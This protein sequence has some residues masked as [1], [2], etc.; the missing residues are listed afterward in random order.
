MRYTNKEVKTM[1]NKKEVKKVVLN[2]KAISSILV[3]YDKEVNKEEKAK[4]G[5]KALVQ[6]L[7]D[8]VP[9]DWYLM[10]NEPIANKSNLID[11]LKN[12]YV[13]GYI[14][15][16]PELMHFK[17]GDIEYNFEVSDIFESDTKKLLEKYPNAEGYAFLVKAGGAR[18]KFSSAF[19][20]Y[21]NSLKKIAKSLFDTDNDDNDTENVDTQ[22]LAYIDSRI[23][24]D[25]NNRKSTLQHRSTSSKWYS[26][27]QAQLRIA[28]IDRAIKSI[29]SLDS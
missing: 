1:S 24:S 26:E 16:H 4:L 11:I 18:R 9:F 23:K 17:M 14:A 21:T 2:E 6:K 22:S 10:N 20:H 25:M 12:H 13:V 28:I 27:Q 5:K 7:V 19:N 15:E 8:E 3:Q 29:D